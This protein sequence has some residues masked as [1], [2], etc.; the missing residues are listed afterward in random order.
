M[1]NT[2]RFL[3]GV[4]VAFLSITGIGGAV[5]YFLHTP[6]NT[7]FQN[8]P[9]IVL[10]H[11]VLGGVYLAIAP[12]QF[13]RKIRS[14]WPNYHRWSGRILVIVGAI[15]GLTA[16]FMALVIPFSG[17][18]ES[19]INGFFAMMFIVSL[20][21]GIFYIRIKQID[22]HR[23]WMIRAFSLGLGVA[24]MRLIFI[25]ALIILGRPTHEQAVMLSIISFTLAFSIHAGLAEIW[26]RK[27][28]K[29]IVLK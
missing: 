6:S 8:F 18:V 21:K 15:V 22:L 20:A 11:V 25:P 9:T 5:F 24:T 14:R 17:W 19:V 23:E 29:K 7:G 26:I 2:K 3:L 1:S 16:I 12:F 4:L 28:R 13:I 27:T 10:L